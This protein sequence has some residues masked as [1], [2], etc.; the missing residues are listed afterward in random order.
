MKYL[1]DGIIDGEITENDFSTFKEK[2]GKS[3]KGDINEEQ[4]FCKEYK[5]TFKSKTGLN[6]HKTRMHGL[7]YENRC[8]KCHFIFQDKKC[9][10]EHIDNCGIK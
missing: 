5:K 6:I 7:S 10:A 4:L 8:G 1:L 3:M 9:L 2:S